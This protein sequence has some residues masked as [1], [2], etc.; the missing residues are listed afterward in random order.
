LRGWVGSGLKNR[1]REEGFVI[2]ASATLL[3][4]K[5]R[6]SLIAAIGKNREIGKDNQLLWHISDDL[7]RFKALT[8]GHPVIMGRKT[9]E[10]IGRPLPNRTN[11][12]VTRNADWVHQEVLVAHTMEEA[13]SLAAEHGSE[14]FVIGGE[15]IY[16]QAIPFADKLYLTLIEDE[17]EADAFFPEYKM[18]FQNEVLRETH[19]TPEGMVYTLLDLER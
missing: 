15:E 9:F 12:V 18:L 1:W 8:T 3:S 10:S 16:K 11:I 14:A 17:K 13:L 4:M 19:T 2:R 6:V 7:K 5:P